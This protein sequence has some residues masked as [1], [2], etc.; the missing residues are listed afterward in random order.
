M[1]ETANQS[2]LILKKLHDRTPCLSENALIDG[3]DPA[4]DIDD[5]I[6]QKQTKRR[7]LDFLEATVTSGA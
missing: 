6:D 7:W 2:S 3:M 5:G 4:R 1:R